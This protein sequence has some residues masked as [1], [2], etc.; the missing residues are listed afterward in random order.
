MFYT[1]VSRDAV[2]GNDMFIAREPKKRR[3]R[4]NNGSR[5]YALIIGA[6]VC[7]PRGGGDG[8]NDGGVAGTLLCA[9]AT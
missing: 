2:D 4:L 9:G 3:W 7:I 5:V 6:T 8:K 1:L